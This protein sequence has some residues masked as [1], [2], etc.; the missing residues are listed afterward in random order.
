MKL[1]S[2]YRIRELEFNLDRYPLIIC[3]GR[4]YQFFFFVVVVEDLI[5][6]IKHFM[7]QATSHLSSRE[8]LPPGLFIRRGENLEVKKL[9][10]VVF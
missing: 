10:M 8:M 2:D 7:N 5:G 6:F 9:V 3:N 4:Y 1:K